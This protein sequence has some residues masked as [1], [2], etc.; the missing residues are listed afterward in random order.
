MNGLLFRKRLVQKRYTKVI[1]WAF[2]YQQNKKNPLWFKSRST[3]RMT[4]KEE[5]KVLM[6]QNLVTTAF[7]WIS[8]TAFIKI[9]MS[10][11]QRHIFNL[12]E[13][14]TATNRSISFFTTELCIART[15]NK[16]L[17]GPVLKYNCFELKSLLVKIKFMMLC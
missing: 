13:N 15:L 14:L 8:P 16:E 5:V 4:E 1:I 6:V 9:F 7:T 17:N 11:I 2:H 10:Q 12:W 3:E